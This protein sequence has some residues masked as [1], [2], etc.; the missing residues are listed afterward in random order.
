MRPNSQPNTPKSRIGII[1]LFGIAGALVSLWQ[2][3]RLLDYI[4]VSVIESDQVR[5]PQITPQRPARPEAEEGEFQ[6]QLDQIIEEQQVQ[7]ELDDET[8]NDQGTQIDG[9]GSELGIG[10]GSEMWQEPGGDLADQSGSQIQTG[11]TAGTISP[12]VQ[13]VDGEDVDLVQSQYPGRNSPLVLLGIALVG[14]IVGFAIGVVVVRAFEKMGSKWDRMDTADKVDLMLGIFVGIAAALPFLF[15]IQSL[16]GGFL[17]PVIVL[18]LVV[19]FSSISV[20][21][22][23]SI[24]TVLPWHASGGRKKKT[25]IKVLDTSVIIDGRIY[26][27]LQAGFL[28]GIVYVPKFVLEELQHIADSADDMRRQRGRR[29]LEILRLMQ[30][31]YELET[32]TYDNLAPDPKADVDSKLVGLAREVGGDLVTNDYNLNRVAR[33]QGV[34]VLNINDLALALRPNVLPGE[35]LTLKLI[36][37]GNQPGQAVGYLEDGTMVVV[38]KAK[39][40]IEN[41]VEVA[42]TQVIQTER[43]KLLFAELFSDET[44]KVT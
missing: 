8:R 7:Q 13:S 44:H 12:T 36:R 20:Y 40:M 9:F 15:V 24:S 2:M 32:G 39:Q 29:G 31:D 14:F 3:P 5:A 11:A 28:E 30:A 10:D 34:K 23:K 26:D 19:G 33:L 1:L 21:A 22:I 27:V 25:D 42:V 16:G 37:E 18:A 41:V 43:G 17:T 6:E 38:E 4:Y 35:I